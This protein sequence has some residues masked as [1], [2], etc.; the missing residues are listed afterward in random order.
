MT[1]AIAVPVLSLV[2]AIAF[3]GIA[4]AQPPTDAGVAPTSRVRV[5]AFVAGG[6]AGTFSNSTDAQPREDSMWPNLGGGLGGELL[7]HRF[8]AAGL[9]GRFES[10]KPSEGGYLEARGRSV[11]ISIVPRGILDLGSIELYAALPFGP[12][13]D[14]LPDLVGARAGSGVG[15]HIAPVLGV[16]VWGDVIGWF[17]SAGYAWH[18]GHLSVPLGDGREASV[19]FDR[20]ELFVDTGIGLRL[21]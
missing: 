13:L 14:W 6:F 5:F 8:F 16:R 3:P 1:R 11:D 17:F 21:F 12:T 10:W 2:V 4:G 19:D 7:V 18:W 15:F 20:A 9:E